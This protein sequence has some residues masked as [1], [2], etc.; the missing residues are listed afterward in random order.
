MSASACTRSMPGFAIFIE[1]QRST[2][3]Q[4]A[5]LRPSVRL[6]HDRTDHH[7]ILT[8]HGFP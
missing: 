4:R 6:S 8:L 3:M 5:I 1:R 2:A 7:A